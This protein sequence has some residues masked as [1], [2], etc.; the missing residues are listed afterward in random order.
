MS[1]HNTSSENTTGRENGGKC[2]ICSRPSLAS[3]TPFCSEKC[4][5]VDLHRWL[6]GVY[7]VPTDEIPDFD[8]NQQP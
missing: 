5:L 4:R 1:N 2:P 6:G 3:A 7:A 8:E